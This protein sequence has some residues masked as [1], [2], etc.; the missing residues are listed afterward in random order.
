MPIPSPRS[1]AGRKTDAHTQYIRDLLD[2]AITAKHW[3]NLF[4]A[5]K[6][7]ARQG[8]IRA[9]HLLIAYRFGSPFADPPE[10][11]EKEIRTIEARSESV[12]L[13]VLPGGIKIPVDPVTFERYPDVQYPDTDA[14]ES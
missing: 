3:Q 7:R 13:E 14:P 8:D 4:R 6:K 11:P 5:L 12:A 10:P 1:K 2:Q 9:A